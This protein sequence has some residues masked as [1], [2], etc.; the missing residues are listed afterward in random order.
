MGI[1]LFSKSIYEKRKLKFTKGNSN[2]F[3]KGEKKEAVKQPLFYKGSYTNDF[4][5]EPVEGLPPFLFAEL[6]EPFSSHPM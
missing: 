4:H 1:I 2:S 3:G 5:S 6:D